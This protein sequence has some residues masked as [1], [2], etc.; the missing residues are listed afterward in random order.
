MSDVASWVAAIAELVGVVIGGL[1][2][3][4]LVSS[5]NTK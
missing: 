5:R 3:A 4:V 2:L 1:Q